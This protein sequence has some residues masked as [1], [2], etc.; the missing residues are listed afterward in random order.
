M[1]LGVIALIFVASLLHA[2]WNLSAKRVPQ[3]GATFVWLYVS[4]AAVVLVPV[5]LIGWGG[6]VRSAWLVP[7]VGSGVLQMGHFLAL[8]RGYAMGDLSVV[9]PLARGS[10]PPL[11]VAA[12]I[13]LLGEKPGILALVGVAAVSVGVVAIGW[14]GRGAHGH[15]F[16]SVWYGLVAGAFIA[17]FTVWDAVAV[18]RLAVPPTMMLAG[19]AL[20]QA[21]LLTPYGLRRLDMAGG[22]WRQHWREV[23][24]IAMLAPL[25]YVM[26]LFAMRLAP[27]SIVAPARELSI[28][29]GIVIGWLA[30]REPAPARRLAGAFIVLA[31]IAAIAA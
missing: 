16:A 13:V 28:V 19:S 4:A 20:T 11:A 15:H 17:A 14:R 31:G 29:M 27:V 2:L 24:T 21:L 3:G 30:L 1:S 7:L 5:A 26:V 10:G 23:M 6:A 9:Y 12:A 8:Q 22:L 18:T 25:S